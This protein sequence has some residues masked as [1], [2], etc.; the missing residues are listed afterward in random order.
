MMKLDR[1]NNQTGRLKLL[2]V[3]TPLELA[4]LPEETARRWKEQGGAIELC[5]FGPIVAATRTA[6]LLAALRPQ[7]V[8]LTGIAGS[9]GTAC[10]IGKAYE[11][12]SVACHGIGVGEG[13]AHRSAAELGWDERFQLPGLPSRLEWKAAVDSGASSGIPDHRL[14]LSVCAASADRSE[15]ADRARRYPDAAAE[16]MESYA[17]AVASRLAGVPLRIVRGISNLA[18][19]RHHRNWRVEAA[20]ADAFRLIEHITFSSVREQEQINSG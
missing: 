19:D 16:D 13:A 1:G 8:I 9:Y 7:Q 12:T 14:L 20:L 4:A 10:E 2:L 5:G 18:G 3:P 15:A 17:V 11:F 6:Q